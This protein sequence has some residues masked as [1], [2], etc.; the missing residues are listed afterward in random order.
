MSAKS[1]WSPLI[2]P[3]IYIRDKQA[4]ADRGMLEFLGKPIDVA[5]EMQKNGI[6]LIHIIDIQA[7]AGSSTNLDI[8]DKLTYLINVEVEC[9]PNE[10]LIR[11]FL[12]LRCR[13]VLKGNVDVSEY[14]EQNLL[15]GVAG[16]TAGS[17]VSASLTGFKDVIVEEW[18]DELVS[19]LFSAKKRIIL[20]EKD[21]SKF[22][23]SENKKKKLFGILRSSS[24]RT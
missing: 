8:Y 7:L 15:V 4:F 23:K 20:F 1:E 13:V 18:D 6:K 5:K 17:N 21:I 22:E 24:T 19:K 10:A 16:K 14:N 3:I 9:A 11:K 2:I 12:S